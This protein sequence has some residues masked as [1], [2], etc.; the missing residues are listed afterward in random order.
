MA[1]TG[2][3]PI[4]HVCKTISAEQRIL[5]FFVQQFDFYRRSVLVC[6]AEESLDK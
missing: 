5:I 3:V 2:T 4:S 1:S 6:V